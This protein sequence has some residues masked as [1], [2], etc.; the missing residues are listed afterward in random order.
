MELKGKEGNGVYKLQ[1]VGMTD[2]CV[3]MDQD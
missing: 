3:A 2:V 1:Q